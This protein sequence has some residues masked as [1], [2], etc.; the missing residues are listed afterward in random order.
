MSKSRR[1]F[2]RKAS[3]AS[4]PLIVKSSVLGREGATSPN[5]RVQLACIGVGGQGTGNMNNFLQDNRVKVLAVCDVDQNHR[6]RALGIAKLNDKDG[7]TVQTEPPSVAINEV[8]DLRGR[9]D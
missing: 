1:H 9:R 2:L 7:Y 6:S 4:V 8:V 3:L 5:S